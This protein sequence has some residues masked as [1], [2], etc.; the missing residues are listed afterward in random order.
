MGFEIKSDQNSILGSMMII[1]VKISGF[2]YHHF[3]TFPF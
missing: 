3:S 1:E 2:G